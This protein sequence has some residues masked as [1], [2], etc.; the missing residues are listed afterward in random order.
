MTKRRI[1]R[2]ARREFALHGFD[3]ASIRQ[4]AAEAA[5]TKPVLYYYFRDKRNLYLSLLEAAV[6]PLC[7]AVERIAEG[8]GSPL[9]RI[10]EIVGAFLDFFRERPDEFQLLHQA[11]ERREREV[12]IIA[13][14]HFR[15][16][17][18]AISRVLTEGVERGLFRSI[19]VSQ[20]TFSVI[21]ILV[22]YLMRAHVIDEVLGHKGASED[23][24]GTLGQH[25][26]GL[27]R[28]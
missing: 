25:I 21:A 13:Q 24:T 8:P 10:E 17:F 6:V 9:Q 18:V 27:L 11:V 14:K 2:V 22:Y 3:G 16:I 4:I 15:R 7:E 19:N 23:L 20:T 28:A 1:E 26:L 12:Q 5:V